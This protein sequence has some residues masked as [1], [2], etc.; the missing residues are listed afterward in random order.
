MDID[1]I[2]EKRLISHLR[3]AASALR[4]CTK[5]WAQEKAIPEISWSKVRSIEFQETMR[6]REGLVRQLS[7]KGC[8]LCGYFDAHVS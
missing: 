7:T 8:V 3:Q 2:V 5:A 6:S 1:A 4:D